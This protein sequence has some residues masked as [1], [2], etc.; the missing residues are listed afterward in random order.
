MST[1]LRPRLKVRYDQEIRQALKDELGLDNIM[2][3]PR[4]SKI[5]LNSGVGRATQQVSLL[6][7]APHPERPAA[8][9]HPATVRVPRAPRHRG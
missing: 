6:D 7:V 2:Q 8:E 1:A 3:V 5:V 9:A 4:L